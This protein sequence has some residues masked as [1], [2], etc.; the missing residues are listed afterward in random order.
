M[1]FCFAA[2]ADFI[3]DLCVKVFFEC[4]REALFPWDSR[5]TANK[6]AAKSVLS[7]V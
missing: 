1:R 2:F 5:I 4:G 3:C 7:R 6:D